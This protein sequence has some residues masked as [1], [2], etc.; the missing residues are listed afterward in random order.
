METLHASIP[1]FFFLVLCAALLPIA[2]LLI[3]PR[4]GRA[5]TAFRNIQSEVWCD[6]CGV[7]P[8]KHH[9]RVRGPRARAEAIF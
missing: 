8:R 3:G 4:R 5:K 1:F 9:V 7:R 2:A 6:F